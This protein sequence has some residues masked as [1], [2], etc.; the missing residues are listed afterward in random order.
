MADG[1][2]R[3]PVSEQEPLVRAKNFDEVCLGYTEEEAVAEAMRCLNCKKPMCVEGCP[4]R[5]NIPAFIHAVAERD[6]AGAYEILSKSSALPA[7]CGRVCPRR[8]SARASAYA[9][10]RAMP[11]RSAS[12]RD[13]LPTGQ[14]QT[15]SSLTVTTNP[16]DTR[17]P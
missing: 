8:H 10:S 9:A 1:F 16:T 11:W 4:V 17:W 14:G 13:L 2:T 12:L 15:A 3:V 6:F 5:I 7:V